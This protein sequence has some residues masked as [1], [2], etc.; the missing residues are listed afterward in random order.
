[1][2]QS[3]SQQITASSR[4]D[5]A[6]K[7]NLFN[8]LAACQRVQRTYGKQGE[9]LDKVVET[10]LAVLKHHEPSEVIE[11]VRKWIE[12]DPNFPTPSDIA[13]IL[14]PVKVYDKSIYLDLIKRRERENLPYN[15]LKYIEDYEANVINDY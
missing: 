8:A 15:K 5:V 14:N 1:M 9:N 2:Q 11:A 3:D 13:K 10:F 12:Q 7:R 6:D 4:F